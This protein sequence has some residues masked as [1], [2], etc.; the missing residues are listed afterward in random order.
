[1][2][3]PIPRN[4]HA[5]AVYTQ[6]YVLSRRVRRNLQNGPTVLHLRH[7]LHSQRAQMRQKGSQNDNIPFLSQDSTK[8]SCHESPKEKTYFRP[9][10]T[11]HA[12]RYPFDTLPFP[13]SAPAADTTGRRP[14]QL[15]TI[16]THP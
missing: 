15:W 12:I 7:P 6:I 16:P 8:T 1:M 11:N 5:D 4:F 3:I 2:R 13:E 9:F 14:G 10:W